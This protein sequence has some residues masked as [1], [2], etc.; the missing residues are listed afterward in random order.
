MRT[1]RWLAIATS[2]ALTCISA[3][4]AGSVFYDALAYAYTNEPDSSTIAYGFSSDTSS[5]YPTTAQYGAAQYSPPAGPFIGCCAGS[6]DVL[7]SGSPADGGTV[8]VKAN[9]Y[10]AFHSSSDPSVLS[11][12]AYYGDVAA[13]SKL[14]SVFMLVGPSSTTP[15][16]VGFDWSLVSSSTGS[17]AAGGELAVYRS[18]GANLYYA[19]DYSDGGDATDGG[20]WTIDLLPNTAYVLYEYASVDANGGP[21]IYYDPYFDSGTASITIDPLFSLTAAEASL[22]HFEGLPLDVAAGP[23]S[24]AVPEPPVMTL[25][26]VGMAFALVGSRRLRKARCALVG[27]VGGRDDGLRDFAAHPPS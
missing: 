17:G 6:F 10:G 11:D 21:N 7:T 14:T 25:L 13:S 24:S 9:G 22:Y 2:A 18:S 26:F 23:P 1:S 4:A 3:Q 5:G 16:K 19:F 27:K 15:I 20:A 8:S 12:N